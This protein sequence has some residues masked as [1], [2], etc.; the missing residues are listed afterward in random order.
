MFLVCAY[1][2]YTFMTYPSK[3]QKCNE[4]TIWP[5]VFQYF[6]LPIAFHLFKNVSWITCQSP[7]KKGFWIFKSWTFRFLS[8]FFSKIWNSPLYMHRKTETKKLSGKRATVER[9]WLKFRTD[10]RSTISMGY[11][12][13][14]SVCDHLG[15]SVHLIVG[16][17]FF[18]KIDFRKRHFYCYGFIF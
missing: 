16:L 9:N 1:T 6:I 11:F 17:F 2:R 3:S 8:I 13:T 12:W 4:K 5:N 10:G 7:Y 14:C 15:H 18:R